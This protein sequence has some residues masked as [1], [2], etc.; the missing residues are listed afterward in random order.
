M[1]EIG[2]A[3]DWTDNDNNSGGG[4]N[5]SLTDNIT[6]TASDPIYL[7][8]GDTFDGNGY[9]ITL[10][11][12]SN[13]SGLFILQ[14]GT[15]KDLGVVTKGGCTLASNKGWLVTQASSTSGFGTIQETV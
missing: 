1:T 13:F 4:T 7:I 3:T 15:I 9:I 10:E 14:G 8:A 2:S 12:R 5:F 6:L 11:S